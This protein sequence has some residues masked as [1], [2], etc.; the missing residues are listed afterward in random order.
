MINLIKKLFK[1]KTEPKFVK[2]LN[3]QTWLERQVD[4]ALYKRDLLNHPSG[5]NLPSQVKEAGFILNPSDN[6][7]DKYYDNE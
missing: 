7:Y 1:K 6:W 2:C 5:N 3:N 4:D